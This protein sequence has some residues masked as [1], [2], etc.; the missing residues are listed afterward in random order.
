M[1]KRAWNGSSTLPTRANMGL[2]EDRL[3]LT[4]AKVS[5]HNKNSEQLGD[6]TE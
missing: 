4:S 1:N 5:D 6:S 3:L 2:R